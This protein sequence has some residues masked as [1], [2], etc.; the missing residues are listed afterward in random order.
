M[1]G[2]VRK[3]LKRLCYK[4]NVT[5]QYSP[6]KPILITYRK[7]QPQQA[8]LVD[9]PFFSEEKTRHVQSTTGSFLYYGRTIEYAI[10]PALND[11]SASQ[12]QP[13]EK[14]QKKYR[15]LWIF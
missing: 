10:L 14:Q 5:P 11:I 2:Y 15:N 8:V 4:P 12:S 6:H 7:N 13:M 3:S 9:S 1:P